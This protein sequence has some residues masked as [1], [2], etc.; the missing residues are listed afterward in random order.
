[1]DHEPQDRS[2]FGS[3]QLDL[4]HRA[5]V[6]GDEPQRP[7]VR[8]S[9]CCCP[10]RAWSSP[11]TVGSGAPRA[12]GAPAG[13]LGPRRARRRSGGREQ[14]GGCDAPDTTVVAAVAV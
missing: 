9:H 12:A 13:S 11:A 10:S 5:R 6:A 2:A 7:A 3:G 1:M 8:R 4:G 14:Q